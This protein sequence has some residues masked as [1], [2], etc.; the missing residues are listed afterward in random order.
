MLKG[1]RMT[2]VVA[3]APGARMPYF[4]TPRRGGPLL[5]GLG[6]V[7]CGPPGGP[8]GGP[9]GPGWPF[10]PGGGPGWPCGA[11]AVAAVTP[12]KVSAPAMAIVANVR[13]RRRIRHRPLPR[14]W[15]RNLHRSG[16][17]SELN[18]TGPRRT[19]PVP[20][21]SVRFVRSG[22][23]L[24]RP[25]QPQSGR[26]RGGSVMFGSPRSPSGQDV[27]T[28]SSCGGWWMVD[29]YSHPDSHPAQDGL[30]GSP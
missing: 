27:G 30:T 15:A 19:S 14:P 12:P 24:E 1:R 13:V 7:G 23:G 29:G 3:C 10:W 26:L 6:I 11:L 18:G 5:G 21:R 25:F 9:G 2:E 22:S 17:S 28:P 16:V 4:R 8:G 20:P